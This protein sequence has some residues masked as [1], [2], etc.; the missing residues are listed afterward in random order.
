M[1]SAVIYSAPVFDKNLNLYENHA[2]KEAKIL[3][4]DVQQ[5]DERGSSK[6][7]H[8]FYKYETEAGVQAS[9]IKSPQTAKTIAQ[10]PAISYL[11][12]FLVNEIAINSKSR[13]SVQL[14]MSKSL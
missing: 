4:K 13:I 7:N 12:R 6:S 5:I 2:N 1:L 8:F 9:N 10:P 11:D 14:P 3:S